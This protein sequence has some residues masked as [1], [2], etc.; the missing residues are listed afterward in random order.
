MDRGL[1]AIFRAG[2]IGKQ[3]EVRELDPRACGATASVP[4]KGSCRQGLLP[5]Q[6]AGGGG[7][8]SAHA[9]RAGREPMCIAAS[10]IAIRQALAYGEAVKKRS[11]SA[12]LRHPKLR[13]VL[14]VATPRH[15]RSADLE[16]DF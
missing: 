5:L 1:K 3:K 2:E 8:W 11:M 7:K 13:Q 12:I 14:R 4:L 6:K 9:G 10:Q 15:A 16:S